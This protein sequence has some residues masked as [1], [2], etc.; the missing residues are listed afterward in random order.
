MLRLLLLY[1]ALQFNHTLKLTFAESRN[2]DKFRNKR[3]QFSVS[4][5]QNVNRAIQSACD[6]AH[7][8]ACMVYVAFPEQEMQKKICVLL[9]QG[10]RLSEL[11]FQF[12]C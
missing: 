4:D 8:Y 12:G 11:L 3:T 1:R 2:A 9:T 10:E 7:G 6:T 5:I